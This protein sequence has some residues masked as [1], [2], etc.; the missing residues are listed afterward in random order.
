[1]ASRNRSTL[2]NVG[3]RM[4]PRCAFGIVF[5]KNVQRLDS[6]FRP[7]V[8][9]KVWFTRDRRPVWGAA[10]GCGRDDH[11]HSTNPDRQRRFNLGSL[12]NACADGMGRLVDE[13]AEVVENGRRQRCDAIMLRGMRKRGTR[14]SQGGVMSCLSILG[15]GGV[16]L[17]CANPIYLTSEMDYSRGAKY[18][19][20]PRQDQF[21]KR[22]LKVTLRQNP[23]C[24]NVLERNRRLVGLQSPSGPASIPTAFSNAALIDSTPFPRN[25]SNET[26]GTP[27]SS[28]VRSSCENFPLP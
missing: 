2:A 6:H 16:M 8:R 1:M 13:S 5:G 22:R 26:A 7:P 12:S 14:F 9:R 25:P 4:R 28:I 27:I 3:R 18:P 15:E 10:E 11:K 20:C 19:H 21:G 23:T 17:G 24:W